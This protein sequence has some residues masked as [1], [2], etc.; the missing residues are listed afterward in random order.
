MGKAFY[1]LESNAVYDVWSIEHQRYMTSEER[2]NFLGAT[3]MKS[4]PVLGNANSMPLRLTLDQLLQMAEGESVL[5]SLT[6]REG[7]VFK[8]LKR[9]EGQPISFK[10][11]NNQY[12]LGE[13]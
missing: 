13:K 11:I 12:L 3:F 5:N 1:L 10:V 9:I 7:L 8:S 4:V 2:H 6:V